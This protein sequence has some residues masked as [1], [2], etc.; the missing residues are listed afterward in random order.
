MLVLVDRVFKVPQ[1]QVAELSR[2]PT[3]SI[4]AFIFMAAV[5]AGVVEEA[6][7]RGYMQVPLEN[8]YGLWV[9]VIIMTTFPGRQM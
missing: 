4:A 8:R 7:F 2:Y 6:A 3:L 1:P 9:A 5:V